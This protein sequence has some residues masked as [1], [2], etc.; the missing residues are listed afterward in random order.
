VQF[1]GPDAA[2]C[3]IEVAKLRLLKGGEAQAR[4]SEA[5]ELHIA[6]SGDGV[7]IHFDL[8]D[9]GLPA[10]VFV[11]GWCCDRS[12][13]DAQVPAFAPRHRVVRLDLAGHGESGRGR[14][15]WSA[16]AFGEDVAAVV[17]QIGLVQVAL[18]DHSMGGPV[19]VEA[20]RRLPHIVIGLIGADTWN[21]VR[22]PQAIAE[23]VARSRVDFPATMEKFVRASFL[24]GAVPTLVERVVA[25]MSAASPEVAISTISEVGGNESDLKQGLR[26][27]AV[28]KIAINARPINRTAADR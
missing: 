5:K 25:G 16:A 28:P 1:R 13:W 3:F 20:A 19:I 6:V 24:D 22:S 9:G 26:K 14:S 18:I 11:H 17:R 10:L 2:L 8:Y 7:P 12:Y 4:I 21:L 23:F 27:I 15:R